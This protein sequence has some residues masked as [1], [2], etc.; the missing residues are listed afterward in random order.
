MG[1]VGRFPGL[2]LQIRIA[3]VIVPLVDP[4]FS[5]FWGRHHDLTP[6]IGNFSR[7]FKQNWEKLTLCD[8]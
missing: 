1:F 7:H 2:L 6:R 4:G 3:P 5:P 8:V